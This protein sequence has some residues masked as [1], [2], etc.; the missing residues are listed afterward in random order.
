MTPTNFDLK[1]INNEF[2]KKSPVVHLHSHSE[3]SLLDGAS[4]IPDMVRKAV[5]IG[6]P[7]QA[8]TDHGVMYGAL[9]FYNECKKEKITPIIGVEAYIA[10]KTRFD[11]SGSNDAAHI[12][13]LV[14]DPEGYRNLIKLVSLA[15]TEGFY[16]RPR[17]DMDLLAKYNKG[18]ICLSGCLS[19][20][21]QDPL[22]HGDYESA[23]SAAQA[24]KDIFEDRFYLEMMRH[25]L[26]D[27]QKV[28]EGMF[29][30]REELGVKFVATNDSHY[31][32]HED[33]EPHAVLCCLQKG[34]TITDPKRFKLPNDQFYIKTS[35]EM[36][37]VFAD[38][39]EACDATLEIAARISSQIDGLEKSEIFHIPTYPMPEEKKTDNQGNVSVERYLRKL[40]LGGL[41]LRYGVERVKNDTS[42]VERMNYEL[43]VIEDMGF[44][45]YF[46][47]V[48]DFI[49]FARD[50][51]IPVGP[52]RGSAV[53]SIVSYCLGITDLCPLEF[54]L[55]F[56]RFLNP[57]RI[58]MPDIDIDFCI[59]GREKVIAYVTEKYG[60]EQVA[61][62][63]T[64]GTMK[65][66]G[67]IKGA[68]RALY[69]DEILPTVNKINKMI[70]S[71]HT[72][73]IKD[74]R[75]HIAEIAAMERQ[76]EQ[77]KRVMETAEQL[78]GYVEKFG[79]HAAGVVIADAPITN[80]LPLV[81]IKKKGSEEISIN[82]EF[83]MD[84]IE[85]LGLLKMDFL[86]LKNLT[87]MKNAEMEIRRTIDPNFVLRT[88]T[89]TDKKTYAMIARGETSGVF[90]L[91]SEGMKRMLIDM[92]P[93]CL[94][95][96]IAGVSLYR[97]GPMQYIPD[98]NARKHGKQTITYLHPKLEAILK[99]TYGIAVYQE[100]IMRIAREI[101]GFTMAEAD[102]LRKIMGK[103]QTEKIAKE[104]D[105]FVEGA[106][107]QGVAKAVAERIFEFMKPF[108]EYGFN[109]AH[110]AAYGWIAYQTA[111]LKENY[112]VQYLAA[113]MT[114]A[115]ETEKLVEYLEEARKMGVEVLPPDIN[116][117]QVGFSVI[118]KQ[119]RFGFEK[120]GG[121]SATAV[122]G[123]IEER[124][125]KR[126]T[127]IYDLVTRTQPLG[128]QKKTA[129]SLVK[130]GACDTLDG[131]RAQ[132][133]I[134]IDRAF[135]IAKLDAREQSLGQINMFGEINIQ[136]IITLPD[137]EKASKMTL[138]NWEHDGLGIYIS[139]HP[140]DAAK[141]L[142]EKKKASTICD[143]KKREGQ[144][145]LV[146]GMITNI[147]RIMTKANNQMMLVASIED[148]TGSMEVVLFPKSY[149]A[150]QS[151]FIENALVAIAGRIGSKNAF[152]KD[153]DSDEEPEII[154]QIITDGVEEIAPPGW[155]PVTKTNVAA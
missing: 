108:A 21:V 137:V 141:D 115:D 92:K 57:S 81:V 126:F 15:W 99:D 125:K 2:R 47:I 76:S 62:I 12:T 148:R 97:P 89:K 117:S 41:R 54:E 30:L 20:L 85:Y 72:P 103:K 36:R 48:W 83:E 128:L 5:E 93:D 37:E 123:I 24:Y 64:Y 82:T 7:A 4:R 98:Y 3:F 96:I 129:E 113:L 10:P 65:T 127:N 107:K 154:M 106:V 6:A 28:E 51:D 9:D 67:A 138:L 45:S 8:L 119:I 133:I 153:E 35:Q 120:I 49:K 38:I 50:N 142:F 84:K 139:G 19:G 53:G 94:N 58:S 59:E 1:I 121:V 71:I 111:Y 146:G 77:V 134:A 122:I 61:Q 147:K 140:A 150:H 56:E 46:L 29:R 52:G 42:L 22:L 23:K 68:G 63:I 86:G 132:Q 144:K 90:Q 25:N 73:C 55:Y 43:G 87:I 101:A 70:P 102:N 149:E 18:I 91:E 155:E 116:E 14:Q 109:K 105:K 118:G 114:Y 74:V 151:C 78:E 34:T 31:T 88:I 130:V 152:K 32:N 17:I 124:K 39:P 40:C 11:K 13:L 95:D 135:D 104:G 75:K 66:K 80:Y 131:H 110:A 136:E 60:Q 33:H 112:P 145:I 26:P 44:S 100:Q 143:A 27:Q 79:T 69:G 16:Y